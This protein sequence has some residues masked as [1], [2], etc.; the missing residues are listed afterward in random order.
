[1]LNTVKSNRMIHLKYNFVRIFLIKNK[2]DLFR[3]TFYFISNFEN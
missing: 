3:E 2:Y 1:M